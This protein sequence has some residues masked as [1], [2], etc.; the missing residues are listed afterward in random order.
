MSIQD[1]LDSVNSIVE[2]QSL[3]SDSGLE[4]LSY[5]EYQS[6]SAFQDSVESISELQSV[7]ESLGMPRLTAED[8]EPVGFLEALGERGVSGYIPFVGGAVEAL[9]LTDVYLMAE[10]IKDGTGT[11]DDEHELM[12]WWLDQ[13]VRATRG[14]SWGG[15]VGEIASQLPAFAGEFVLTGGAFTAGRKVG[16]KAARKLISSAVESTAKKRSTQLFAKR[17]LRKTAG[18]TA[19]GVAG[20]VSQ[21]TIGGALTSRWAGDTLRNM[22]PG[23]GLTEDEYGQLALVINEPDMHLGNAIFRGWASQVRE[24]GSERLGWMIGKKGIGRLLK[25]TKV[26]DQIKGWR[27]AVSKKWLTG[28]AGRT[29]DQLATLKQKIGWHGIIGEIFEERAGE[30]IDVPIDAMTLGELNYAFPGW[31]HLTAEAVAF[32]LPGAG[33]AA[34]NQRGIKK[35]KRQVGESVIRK[36]AELLNL[37]ETAETTE[38]VEAPDV[39]DEPDWLQGIAVE[40]EPTSEDVID[41][42]APSGRAV[43]K[44]AE[45]TIYGE[46]QYET[47][48]ADLVRETMDEMLADNQAP[49]GVVVEY[50]DEVQELTPVEAE[51]EAV[52][53]EL[54][55]GEQMVMFSPATE[56]VS[57]ETEVADVSEVPRRAR[58]VI[59]P[60]LESAAASATSLTGVEHSARAVPK[61]EQSRGMR[62]LVAGLRA[63]GLRLVPIDVQSTKDGAS[64]QFSGFASNRDSRVIYVQNSG[65]NAIRNSVLGLVSHEATHALESENPDLFNYL[66]SLAPVEIA[67]GIQQYSQSNLGAGVFGREGA[68]P[69][70]AVQEGMATAVQEAITRIGNIE[71]VT[72]QAE[73]SLLERL[74]DW[75]RGTA[76]RLGLRGKFARELQAV[77][78]QMVA[79][80]D[81]AEIELPRQ[82]KRLERARARGLA[83]R[84]GAVAPAVEAEAAPRFAPAPAAPL[85]LGVFYS[86]MDQVLR[87]TPQRKWTSSQLRAYLTKQGVKP[88]EMFWSG[89]EDYLKENPKV[90]LDEMGDIFTGAGLSEVVKQKEDTPRFYVGAVPGGRTWHVLDR[91]TGQPINSGYFSESDAETAARATNNKMA[92]A[93]KYSGY[94]LPGEKEGYRELLITLPETEPSNVAGYAIKD[95]DGLNQPSNAQTKEEAIEEAGGDVTRVVVIREPVP[96]QNNYRSTHWDEPNVLVHI[97]Y[98]TRRG[99][100]GEKI[101]F[102]EEIQSDWHQQ[103]RKKGYGVQT[104]P[105]FEARPSTRWDGTSM[106]GKYDW[107]IYRVDTNEFID[108]VSGG[109]IG[110]AILLAERGFR[111]REQGVPEAPFKKTWQDLALKRMVGEAVKGEFDAIA[112]TTGKQQANRYEKV[113]VENAD[114][115]IV[116]SIPGGRYVVGAMQGGRPGATKEV[117][118]DELADY[119]GKDMAVDAI[120]RIE[121]GESTVTFETEDFTVG[122]K[123]MEGFYDR[124]L[125][126]AAN[127][128]GKK[129][130][131]T[132]Q[133][134]EMETG[135]QK[136]LP[137]TESLSETVETVGLPKFAPAPA[138]E[139]AEETPEERRARQKAQR[140]RDEAAVIAGAPITTPARQRA[141][142]RVI[143]RGQDEARKEGRAEGRA[144]GKKAEKRALDRRAQSEMRRAARRDKAELR[145]RFQQL[146]RG[147]RFGY[148]AGREAGYRHAKDIAEDQIKRLKAKPK[149]VK[150][151]KADVKKYFDRVFKGR[152][153]ELVGLREIKSLMSAIQ[154]AETPKSLEKA[155]Q[156]ILD[157][158]LA[159]RSKEARRDAKK[160]LRTVRKARQKGLPSE[161]GSRLD[162]GAAAVEVLASAERPK[163]NNLLNKQTN[164][165]VE[166]IGEL[167]EVLAEARAEKNEIVALRKMTEAQAIASILGE[168]KEGKDPISD[169]ASWGGRKADVEGSALSTAGRWH[170]DITSLIQRLTG[171]TDNQSDLYALLVTNFRE[172]EDNYNAQLR[173]VMGKMNDAAIEA[174][175]RS[176]EDAMARMSGSHGMSLVE[177]VE[178]DL[179]SVD[180]RVSLTPAE[181]MHLMLMDPMTRSLIDGGVELSLKRSKGGQGRV[182]LTSADLDAVEQQL[183]PKIVTFAKAMRDVLETDIK[184][185]MFDAVRRLTGS[186]P[187][188]VPDYWPRSRDRDQKTELNVDDFLSGNGSMGQL[189]QIY[190]ENAGATK[191]R[192]QDRSSAIFVTSAM[193][194]FVEHVDMGLR[195]TNF[196]EPIRI[197]DK[198]LRNEDV[199]RELIQRHGIQTYKMLREYVATASGLRESFKGGVDRVV[200]AAQ[201]NVAVSYLAMNPRTWLVQLTS[202]PRFV[203]HFSVADIAEGVRWMLSNIGNLRNIMSEE[204]GYFWRRWARSSAE[205]FGPQKYGEIV[206]YDTEGFWRGVGNVMTNLKS[207]DLRGA[208]RSWS[209]ALDA[210]QILNGFDGMVSGV[211]YGAA[212]ARLRREGVSEADLKAE[213]ASL[214]ADAMRDTQNSTSTLDLTMGALSG[215][216]SPLARMFLMFSS[217]PL[218]TTNILI[219]GGRLMKQGQKARGAEMIAGVIASSILATT[220]RVGWY[221]GMGAV[222]A[223]IGGDDDDKKKADR[224]A[225]MWENVNL[226]LVRELSGLTFFGPAIDLASG[227]IR[228]DGGRNAMESPLSSLAGQAIGATT[229][230]VE[231]YSNLSDVEQDQ[232]LEKLVSAHVK[233]LNEVASLTI[234]NPIRPW[235]N[236]VRKLGEAAVFQDPV[237][238]IRGLVRYYE[239][240]PRQ[241]LTAEQRRYFG[242]AQAYLKQINALGRVISKQREVYEKALETGQDGRIERARN[243]LRRSLDRRAELASRAL[244]KISPSGGG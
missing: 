77:V 190:L 118:R 12:D 158:A 181:A 117:G 157:V 68:G 109:G 145:R 191:T 30:L 225:K 95:K 6:R 147:A 189:A 84:A 89:M 129:Y 242:K 231:A 38:E 45:G 234:G 35:Q 166:K 170:Q 206:P 177:M 123:G 150:R 194:T 85:E 152:N 71:G 57:E 2:E 122:G 18:E 137:I 112:W 230:L 183:D 94:Q 5:Q 98:N 168:I 211:A 105:K 179:P 79:G 224:A 8:M 73:R 244:G 48:D 220:L 142:R 29:V 167:G 16:V 21:A 203:T 195:L 236:D 67:D 19:G 9:D 10:R 127:K 114:Q 37:G 232:V 153:M 23:M 24:F 235:V 121:A 83:P 14:T 102:L 107:D 176:F 120:E 164:E 60:D 174:G 186:E 172:A 205:R 128:I 69:N 228:G 55:P 1:L 222:V 115:V 17:A 13:Q 202:I 56:N 180:G 39:V 198:S 207:G 165:L 86:K 243:V 20:A 82:A 192:Q 226:G 110:E 223:A 22:M 219:Q 199:K 28:K 40:V 62:T 162:E 74:A 130:G 92:G 100:N 139:T 47:E 88:D 218:K 3:R 104:L 204:S 188:S 138:E 97:R 58:E 136:S 131:A 143:K 159:L 50:I 214:A 169:V 59:Q 182:V 70:I 51:A 125:P 184:P 185:G 27:T 44:D 32:A 151:I 99:P 215:R 11:E 133:N 72:D 156:K 201:S 93:T 113:L 135:T 160:L 196:A 193:E 227:I 78:N 76:T 187:E 212:Q 239:D 237:R 66:V 124:M 221:T 146:E 200:A 7:R 178:L 53:E 233:W 63:T 213:A 49:E 149:D 75:F 171:R 241:E 54:Q 34:L 61:S 116:S 144:A 163:N 216:H 33:F 101:L 217:D 41:G 108:S 132:V 141:Q 161:F 111:N 31:E 80:R 126:T 42:E 175:F 229:G 43:F 52:E 148:T 65:E 96:D 103:G 134:I 119:I 15:K 210:I 36:R 154:K 46:V 90:D 173:E 87:D 64:A 209:S 155:L 106:E 240:M 238:Q 208:Y 81:I 140:E 26:E 4:P 91:E 197:G 25:N